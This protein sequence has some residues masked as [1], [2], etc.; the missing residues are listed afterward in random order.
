MVKFH[1]SEELQ[2]LG[3]IHTEVKFNYNIILF[4]NLI[5]FKNLIK[6]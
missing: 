2:Y 6:N 5:K 1:Y 4:L 3:Q